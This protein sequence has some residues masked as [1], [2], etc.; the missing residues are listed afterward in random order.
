MG[1]LIVSESLTLDGVYEGLVRI[2]A[3]SFELAG[4]S[5]PYF[6]EEHAKYL[7]EGLSGG[8]TLPLGRATYQYFQ[9]SWSPQTG[10]VADFMN[11]ARKY[12]V[13]NTLKKA[14]WNNSTLISGNVH[15]EIAKLKQS[16]ADMAI[17]GSG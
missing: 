10:P 9:A 14:D 7:S 3:E 13:S 15:N 5:E 16:G 1:K 12:V 4:W 8:G 17:L 2:P 6:S 11:N